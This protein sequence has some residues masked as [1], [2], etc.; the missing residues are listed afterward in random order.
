MKFVAAFETIG[1]MFLA[2]APNVVGGWYPDFQLTSHLITYELKATPVTHRNV[3][4]AGCH[5]DAIHNV[6][7][8]ASGLLAV[9]VV[10]AATSLDQL[11]YLCQI[12]P[13]ISSRLQ[14]GEYN[15]TL[16][17]KIVCT[18]AG[19]KAIPSMDEI[20]ALTAAL[21]TKIWTIQAIGAV[22][23]RSGLKKLFKLINPRAAS[24]VG[25]VSG[26]VKK[27]VHTAAAV[28]GKVAHFA[29]PAHANLT[30]IPPTDFTPTFE[31][32]L[33]F[34]PHTKELAFIGK[35]GKKP[36]FIGKEG[37]KPSGV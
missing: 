32:V 14:S 25:L 27:D 23:G 19:G 8:S 16:I 18:A 3:T 2:L 30:T 7:D 35:E 37:K 36:A 34:I 13:T 29:K 28:A 21:S 26:L 11:K 20:K 10:G 17:Q 1:L 6:L 33:S 9:Q 22:E 15:I 12:F 5:P 31:S 4:I 24:A